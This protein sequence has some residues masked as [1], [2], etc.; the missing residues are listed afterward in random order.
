[1]GISE[2]MGTYSYQAE[3]C[4]SLG[5]TRHCPFIS[6][7]ARSCALALLPIAARSLSFNHAPLNDH[8]MAWLSCAQAQ[9][10]SLQ[11]ATAS[12]QSAAR[13]CCAVMWHR[14]VDIRHADT[15][16]LSQQRAE[17]RKRDP[18]SCM[19]ITEATATAR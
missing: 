18:R 5:L 3:E 2:G 12:W 9:M 10:Q 15:L 8:C 19:R 7:R 11:S 17:P 1:M 13:R 14:L 4:T 6:A 16:T